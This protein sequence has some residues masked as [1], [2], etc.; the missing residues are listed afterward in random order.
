MTAIRIYVSLQNRNLIRDEPVPPV[1]AGGT[2]VSNR[3]DKKPEPHN[4]KIGK[5]MYCNFNTCVLYLNRCT[6][7]ERGYINGYHSIGIDTQRR[8][9]QARQ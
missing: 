1:P 3:I 6:L 2:A 4:Q 5:K 7:S 9:V 8:S